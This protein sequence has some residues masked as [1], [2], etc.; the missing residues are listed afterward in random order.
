MFIMNA[1]STTC[2]LCFDNSAYYIAFSQHNI[3]S[4]VTTTN[5][6]ATSLTTYPINSSFIYTIITLSISLTITNRS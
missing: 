4:A 2:W 6:V 5:T 1:L 3:F